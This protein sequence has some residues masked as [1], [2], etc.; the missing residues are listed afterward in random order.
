ME[1]IEFLEE[2][3]GILSRCQSPRLLGGDFNL[4]LDARDKNNDNINRAMMAR[5]RRMV[6][7]LDLKEIIMVGRKYTWSNA[8]RSPTLVKL[9]RAI[10]TEDWEALYP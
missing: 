9:D 1:R 7:D 4:I 8:R 2:L 6:N 3:R 5:F 10:C